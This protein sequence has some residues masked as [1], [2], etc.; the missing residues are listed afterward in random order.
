MPYDNAIPYDNDDS[1]I[2]PS[3]APR[4]SHRT[5]RGKE[6][7]DGDREGHSTRGDTS[8]PVHARRGRGRGRDR[9][10]GALRGVGRGQERGRGRGRGRGGHS[11]HR[12]I[13]SM[14]TQSI[15]RHEEYD[16]RIPFSQDF[17][18]S[19]TPFAAGSETGQL[20]NGMQW[21]FNPTHTTM[22]MPAGY[23]GGSDPY[24]YQQNTFHASD[25]SGFGNGL[26]AIAPH[27][28]PSF[29]GFGMGQEMAG[30]PTQFPGNG[31]DP[32]YHQGSS[33]WDGQSTTQPTE[34]F[35]EDTSKSPAKI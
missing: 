6:R 10:R 1:S 32:S 16:P 2:P 19:S 4:F 20:A 26:P 12:D 28:N 29:F 35:V 34:A 14:A 22:P 13:D 27:I 9:D 17:Y 21:S 23:Y 18:P 3:D 8:L 25:P 33:A 24:H 15:E 30:Y 5:T 31:F 11:R 7:F